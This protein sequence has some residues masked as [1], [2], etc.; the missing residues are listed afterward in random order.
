MTKHDASQDNIRK[1]INVMYHTLIIEN[2]SF[3]GFGT[4]KTQNKKQKINKLRKE[5]HD[6]LK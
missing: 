1:S 4:K 5:V 2:G 6:H 3:P